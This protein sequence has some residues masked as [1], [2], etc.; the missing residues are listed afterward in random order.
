MAEHAHAEPSPWRYLFV[1]LSLVALTF[2]T[3]RLVYVDQGAAGFYLGFAI[4]VVKAT[5]VALFFMHLWDQRGINRLV[6]VVALCFLGILMGLIIADAG[7]RFPLAIARGPHL[8]VP[9]R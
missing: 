7:T 3:W 4:A 8:V 9:K 2:L 5:L 1:W 6:F